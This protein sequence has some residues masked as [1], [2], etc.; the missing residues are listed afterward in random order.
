MAGP[1]KKQDSAPQT[2]KFEADAPG[3]GFPREPPQ[4]NMH[5]G[6]AQGQYPHNMQNSTPQ[7]YP[8]LFSAPIPGP[9]PLPP[10]P[11]MHYQQSRA[12]P[13]APGQLYTADPYPATFDQSS[14]QAGYA[15]GPAVRPYQVPIQPPPIQSLFVQRPSYNVPWTTGLFDCCDDPSNALITFCVPCVTFGQAAEIIDEGSS[16]CATHATFY[17]CVWFLIGCPCL[18]SCSYRTKLRAR[19]QLVETPAPDW[20]THFLCEL[21]A[22]CQMHRELVNRGLDPSIGWRANAQ[23]M[24]QQQMQ[25][26]APPPRQAMI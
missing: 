15:P 21:C 6:H 23:R 25:A 26:M 20:L 13:P 3:P 16:S 2:P 8:E 17:S 24:Q 18:L 10:Q 12:P 1:D 22:L 9:Q 5:Y 11:N 14:Q 19:Y 4:P 7:T